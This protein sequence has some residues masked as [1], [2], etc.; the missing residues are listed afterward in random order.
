M[1]PS[2]GYCHLKTS[3]VLLMIVILTEISIQV[4]YYQRGRD[5]YFAD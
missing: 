3:L 1:V 4:E 5:W 2:T